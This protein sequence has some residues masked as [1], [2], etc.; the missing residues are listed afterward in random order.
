MLYSIASSV[1]SLFYTVISVSKDK[2]YHII[3]KEP[4][5][6]TDVGSDYVIIKRMR[7]K[8]LTEYSS[9]KSGGRITPATY[10][11]PNNEPLPTSSIPTSNVSLL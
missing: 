4:D 1:Y 2:T 11:R 7:D 5:E 3:N 6:T 10:T 8:P 9:S